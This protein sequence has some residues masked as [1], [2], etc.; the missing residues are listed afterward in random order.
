MADDIIDAHEQSERA[1]QWLQQNG[2][3][4]IIGVLL[5]IAVL[6]GWQRYQQS[7][8]SHRAEAFVKYEDLRAAVDKED[9][10][11]A[12][13]LAND[14]RK[15]YSDTP[16]AALAAM[17]LA[18]QQI[19]DNK[20][21]EAE[22][23]LRYVSTDAASEPLRAIAAMRLA[24]V[25]LARGEAQKSIDALSKVV[26]D[27][28]SAE[29]DQIRGDALARMG[30]TDE[31]RKAYDAAL[32]SMDVASQQRKGVE[33]KRDDLTAAKSAPVPVAAEQG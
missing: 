32:A 23:S 3:S 11:L 7:G 9:Q 27:A 16:H 8:V 26:G 20:L 15:N 30:Q 4:I 1:R 31:A 29:R 5:G 28:Y 18:E 2:S 6:L 25:L 24:R 33:A 14:L 19:K 22:S 10:E 21:P 12:A 13:N 17:E